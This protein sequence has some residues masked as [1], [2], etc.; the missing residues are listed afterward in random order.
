MRIYS[1]KFPHFVEESPDFNYGNTSPNSFFLFFLFFLFSSFFSFYL[2]FF[3]SFI[4]R[5]SSKSC[6]KLRHPVLGLIF[7]IYETISF[8]V[9]YWTVFPAP[10]FSELNLFTFNWRLCPTIAYARCLFTLTNPFF[11]FSDV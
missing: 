8:Y 10:S 9:A 1:H 2:L 5:S 7:F 11:I 6:L 3:T 4:F